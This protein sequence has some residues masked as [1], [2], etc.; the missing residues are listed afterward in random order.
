MTRRLLSVSALASVLLAGLS[1]SP[2]LALEEADRLWLVGERAF[3]DGLYPITRRAL[4]RFVVEYPN[5]TRAAH[6]MLLL[7]RSRL[8]LGEPEKALDAFRRLRAI[9]SLPAQ[10][11]EARFWEAESLYRLKQFA[12]ARAGY[13]DVIG[14]D[15]ASPLAPEALY[16]L[17]LCELELKRPEPAI[18]AFRDLLA[19]WPEHAVAA[20]ATFYQAQTLADLKRYPEALPLLNGFAAKFPK[21]KLVPDAQYV[22]GSTRLAM[23]ERDAGIAELKAFVAAYPSHPQVAA[24]RRKMT[25]TVA[26]TGTP[27]QQQGAHTQLTQPSATAENLYDAGML[28]GK[29]G[30]AKEQQAAWARL[31]KEFPNHPLAHQA[32]FELAEAS[33]NRKDWAPAAA[34]AKA[35]AA[36]EDEGLR[37]RA[38]LLEGEAELKLSRFKDAAKSF[39]AVGGVKN[40]EPG[41]RYRAL[42]GLGL[43]REQL[44]E[45]RAAL[46]AYDAVASKSPD[47]KLRTWARD[48]A[49]AVRSQPSQPSKPAGN[50]EKKS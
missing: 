30:K 26:K 9:A 37:A 8:A 11:L 1:P 45:I 33:F 25:E 6:A 13:D 24:A 17:G 50:G 42:A 40:L 14:K 23:G 10:Q 7:G 15:A 46:A 28:A 49:A 21:S 44:G 36:S 35:A 19:A 41:D 5:D 32:S 29:Q 43:A 27:A 34:Q 22:L 2:A 48:R 18:K 39:E 16:G 38:L 20:P 31:R 47:A 3:A 4:D 12:A